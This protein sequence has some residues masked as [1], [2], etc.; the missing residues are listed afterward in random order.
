MHSVGVMESCRSGSADLSS[1]FKLLLFKEEHFLFLKPLLLLLLSGLQQ[2]CVVCCSKCG[3]WW[4]FL[5][6]PVLYG[7][8]GLHASCE[9]K[10]C[11]QGSMCVLNRDTNQPEC[12]C[13][14]DCKSNYMPI[15]GSDGRFYENHCQLHRAS[16]LQR[17][18]IYIIH[19]KDCFFKGRALLKINTSVEL[20]SLVVILV[21][22]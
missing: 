14:E 10:Y 4:H 1:I 2:P 9:K 3:L 17:K 20:S 18:K 12:R 19:S 21:N 13:V 16:C 22:G 5:L 8:D 6:L 15:C 11:G 7:Q